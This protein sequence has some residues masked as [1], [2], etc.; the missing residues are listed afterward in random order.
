[1]GPPGPFTGLPLPFTLLDRKIVRE[2]ALPNSNEGQYAYASAPAPRNNA[3]FNLLNR[4]TKQELKRNT[5]KAATYKRST[6]LYRYM[7]LK[8]VYYIISYVTRY[9]C[10]TYESSINDEW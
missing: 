4:Q 7:F 5:E 2:T 6:R 3:R 9:R 10:T 1:M 8:T